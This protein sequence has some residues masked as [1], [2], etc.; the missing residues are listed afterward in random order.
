MIMAAEFDSEK[1]I[2]GFRLLGS[3]WGRGIFII[4]LGS[5]MLDNTLS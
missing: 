3:L 2:K 1:I 5:V 4:F